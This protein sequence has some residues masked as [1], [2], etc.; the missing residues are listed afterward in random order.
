VSYFCEKYFRKKREV[1]MSRNAFQRCSSFRAKEKITLPNYTFRFFELNAIA[2]Y[3]FGISKP[4]M[5]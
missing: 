5:F 2:W 1:D 4:P 3:V